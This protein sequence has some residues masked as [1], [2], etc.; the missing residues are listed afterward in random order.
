MQQIG[1]NTLVKKAC[2]LLN[3]GMVDRVL[4]WRKADTGIVY[5]VETAVFVNVKAIEEV[6]IWTDS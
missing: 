2:E 4:G 6:L 3:A 5:V 1:R